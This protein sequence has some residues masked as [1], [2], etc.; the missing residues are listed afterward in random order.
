LIVVDV[1]SD[2]RLAHIPDLTI[3]AF[4]SAPLRARGRVL[5]TLTVTREKEQPFFSR[6]EIA[7]LTSISDQVGVV[8][9]SA[10]LRQQAE[11]TAVMKERARLAR[12]LH[13]SVTQLLYSVNL[14]AAV[15]REAYHQQNWS[16]VHDSLLELGE[17]AQQALKE[18]RLLVY[19]L[20]PP[21]LEHEGLIGALQQRLDAV[22]GRAGVKAQLLADKMLYLPGPV[23]EALYHVTQEAL[24]NALKHAGATS[25]S[26]QIQTYDHHLQLEISDDGVGFDPSVA[27]GKG[28]MGLVSMRERIDQLGGTLAIHSV[29]GEGTTVKVSLEIPNH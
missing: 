5:G 21:A 25:V 27:V 8:V 3:Q 2:P 28:G 23:E 22:E 29:S 13:D 19:Q 1:P 16:Q 9:E 4:I 18:M 17:V 6:E 11:Q 20:R 26:V 24:N 15:G 12:D 14:F 10:W 7:L